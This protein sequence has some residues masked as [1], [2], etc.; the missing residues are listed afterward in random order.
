[1]P[2]YQKDITHIVSKEE[3]EMMIE[4]ASNLR[5]K[6]LVAIFY[7]T[8]ARINELTKL[9][10]ENITQ[11]EYY[12]EEYIRIKLITEKRRKSGERFMI[13][14]RTLE[15][16]KT[17]PFMDIV[18]SYIEQIKEGPLIKITDRRIRQ[19]FDKLSD[20]TICPNMFRHSRLVKL[21]RAG[22]TIDEL[23]YWK[24]ASDTR[25]VSEY[26]RAKPIGRRL[27]IE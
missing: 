1:M 13:I 27:R 12:G 18:L 5:D 4:R 19:I 17:A 22:A 26:L 23:M 7:L 10:R 6:F 14:E 16:P 24:G 15:I 9:R 20:R 3:A 2:R 21:A 25:S 11:F 8:G